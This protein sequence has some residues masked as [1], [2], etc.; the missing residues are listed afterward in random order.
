MIEPLRTN[1]VLLSE[2]ERVVDE[3]ERVA[4]EL[5]EARAEL[6]EARAEL[7][8]ARIGHILTDK[9]LIKAAR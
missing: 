1:V 6:A 9:N 5:A 7:A 3:Y 4:A 8:E 2:Y